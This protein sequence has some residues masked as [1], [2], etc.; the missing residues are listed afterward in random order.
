MHYNYIAAI[1]RL[2]R[3]ISDA[4]RC[5]C[6]PV[7]LGFHNGGSLEGLIG[8]ELLAIRWC[9]LVTR[10]PLVLPSRMRLSGRRQLTHLVQLLP[11]SFLGQYIYSTSRCGLP[12][13]M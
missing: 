2:A 1:G 7:P 9:N 12:A 4:L 6:G 10:L 5:E 11:S 13:L 3:S 8:A